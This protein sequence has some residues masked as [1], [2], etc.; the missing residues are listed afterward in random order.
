MWPGRRRG[1]QVSN[2]SKF[3]KEVTAWLTFCTLL[4]RLSDCQTIRKE[5]ESWFENPDIKQRTCPSDPKN[6][7]YTPVRAYYGCACHSSVFD[8]FSDAWADYRL[9][10]FYALKPTNDSDLLRTAFDNIM[11]CGDKTKNKVNGRF[12]TEDNIFCLASPASES[13]HTCLWVS[14]CHTKPL[15]TNIS[16]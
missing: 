8:H 14:V 1:C 6:L 11:G 15:Y 16:W 4:L 7:Y 5:A 9:G 13:C 3:K 12:R 10:G 2:S